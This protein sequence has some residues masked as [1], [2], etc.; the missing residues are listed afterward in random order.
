MK[1]LACAALL[2]GLAGFGLPGDAAAQQAPALNEPSAAPGVTSA[3]VPQAQDAPPPGPKASRYTF[4]RIRDGFVRLDSQTGEMAQC[5]W[6]AAGWSCQAVPD[7]RAALESEIARLQAANAALK[8]S[9]LSRGLD[10]PD[11]VRADTPT[12]KAPDTGSGSKKPADGQLDRVVSYMA[13]V[14][15]LLVEMMTDLQRDIQR[16]S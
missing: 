7:E 2:A 3:E 13:K 4:H 16:K 1:R 15:R 10:L 8:K 12:A 14:W 11:G 9:L 5:G 6:S